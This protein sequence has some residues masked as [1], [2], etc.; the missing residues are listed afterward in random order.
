MLRINRITIYFKLSTKLTGKNKMN[1][2]GFHII[3]IIT[4]GQ[5]RGPFKEPLYHGNI[6]K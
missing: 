4:L 6:T 2:T 1:E 3:I 5:V